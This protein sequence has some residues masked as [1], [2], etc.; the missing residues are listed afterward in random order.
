VVRKTL[1]EVRGRE[2]CSESEIKKTKRENIRVVEA[3][4]KCKECN[5]SF[6]LLQINAEA[7]N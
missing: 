7:Q 4:R 3:D 5:S 6:Y 1:R 2:S